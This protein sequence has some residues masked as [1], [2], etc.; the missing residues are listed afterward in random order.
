[1]EIYLEK[2]VVSGQRLLG[3]RVGRYR[4]PF[5]IY[6]RG[7]HGYTGFLRAP[8]IRYS[9]YWALSNNYLETGGSVIAGTTW[10]SAEGS[11][12]VATDED[13]YSRPGGANGV[14]RVQS[15]FGSWIVGA[16]H[17]RTRPS[18]H[19]TFATGPAEFTG[20]D[21]RWMY[22]GVQ[23][24]GEWLSGRPFDG[25]ATRGGYVDVLV[26][27]PSMGPVTAVARI[28]RLDYFAGPFSRFPRRYSLGAKVR[29]SHRL[30][31]QVNLIH[32]PP[33]VTGHA[34][35]TSFDVGLTF[36]LRPGR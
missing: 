10:L 21:V 24:R 23:V 18:A 4:T 11:V 3:A 30:V 33:D 34:G 7:D 32:Q 17:I 20:L 12:G 19:W 26:H 15:A 28:E 31:G 25:A 35:H 13:E 29:V 1:M 5:G 2:T 16:S 27:R 6:G 8:L 14:V 22:A 9:D 36:S